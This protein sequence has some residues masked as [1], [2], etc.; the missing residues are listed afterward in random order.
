MVAPNKQKLLAKTLTVLGK[1]YDYELPDDLQ[2]LDHLLLAVL[3][4][5]MPFAKALKAYDALTGAFYDMNELRVAHPQELE[6]HLHGVPDAA[7]KARRILQILQFVF[8]TTYNYDLESMRRKP[9][10]Q[11]QRQLSQITGT[12]PF[13]VAAA[14]QRG[15][16]GHA[17]PIDDTSAEVLHRL[18]FIEQPVADDAARA[19]MDRLVPKARAVDFCFYVH[20]LAHDTKK[21][22]AALVEQIA[23]KQAVAAPK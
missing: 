9:L 1:Q 5:D 8:E 17:L 13:V 18:G 4:Q 19:A 22:Q 10:K 2:V 12:N 3:Q 15:L 16:G 14:V 23:G 7:D 21:N 6:E 20:G 11:A